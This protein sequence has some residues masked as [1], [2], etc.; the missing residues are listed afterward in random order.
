M[1]TQS[2]TTTANP[3]DPQSPHQARLLTTLFGSPLKDLAASL[4][5]TPLQFLQLFSSPN[6]LDLINQARCVM[7]LTAQA[8]LSTSRP[9]AVRRLIET[10]QAQEPGETLR[11]AANDLIRHNIVP[12]TP[13]DLL[14][15]EQ[16]I[17]YDR[18]KD[19]HVCDPSCFTID[20]DGCRSYSE[21]HGQYIDRGVRAAFQSPVKRHPRSITP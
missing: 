13:T 8:A 15:A 21:A 16:F 14:P 4:D 7:D 5:A 17:P 18:A 3:T 10:L 11:R 12:P 20:P 1:N 19:P 6:A 9:L 2:P